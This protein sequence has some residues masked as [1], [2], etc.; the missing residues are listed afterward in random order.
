MMSEGAAATPLLG[1]TSI[2]IS[3]PKFPSPDKVLKV[4]K[5]KNLDKLHMKNFTTKRLVDDDNLYQALSEWNLK[6]SSL[7][8]NTQKSLMEDMKNISSVKEDTVR[9]VTKKLIDN[10][11]SGNTNKQAIDSLKKSPIIKLMKDIQIKELIDS[12]REYIAIAKF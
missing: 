5:T 6:W 9:L 12:S 2:N 7:D 8:R 11:T 3:T 10:I 4:F 1:N